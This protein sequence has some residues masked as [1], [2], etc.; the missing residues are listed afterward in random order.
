MSQ[1][2]TPMSRL[3]G[4]FDNLNKKIQLRE[5]RTL[6]RRPERTSQ[7]GYYD[8]YV[9]KKIETDFIRLLSV[10]MNKQYVTEIAFSFDYVN[11]DTKISTSVNKLDSIQY[12]KIYSFEEFRQ[13]LKDL[14]KKLPDNCNAD[15]FIKAYFETF[16]FV[17]QEVSDTDIESDVLAV[18]PLIEKYQQ[19]QKSLTSKQNKLNRT[20]YRVSSQLHVSEEYRNL[21]QL[22]ERQKE[23][24]KLIKQSKQQVE[25][26]RQEIEKEHSFVKVKNELSEAR[27]HLADVNQEIDHFAQSVIS[28]Y[29]KHKSTFIRD[30]I[31]SLK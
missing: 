29:P 1:Q 20:Q 15:T 7:Y 21:Q 26:K 23:I 22:L 9:T 19:A 16:E 8:K 11:V 17:S 10:P 14:I 25:S 6:H 18:K 28:R 12:S 13:T 2:I 4:L 24:E 27:Y 31:D 5:L 30:K 3:K